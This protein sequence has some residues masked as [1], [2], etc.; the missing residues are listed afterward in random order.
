MEH[1]STKLVAIALTAIILLATMDTH[2]FVYPSLS[3]TL[4]SGTIITI[5]SVYTYYYCIKSKRILHFSAFQWIILLWMA[6]IVCHRLFVQAENYRLYYLL[7][8]LLFC[9]TV[10]TL[11][12]HGLLRWRLVENILLGV[13]V[14]HVAVIMFQLLKPSK[15]APYAITGC[16]E[17]PTVSAVYLTCCVT[18]VLERFNEHRKSYGIMLL[19]M[20]IAIL[21]LRCRT[22]YIGLFVIFAIYLFIYYMP[23][24]IIGKLS[25]M[26]GCTM[27]AI[28]LS[29]GL[30]HFKQSSSEGRLLIW[31]VTSRMIRENPI[32]YG[33]GLFEKNYNLHQEDYFSSGQGDMN[34]K[35]TATAVYMPYNDVLEQSVEGGITGALFYLLFFAIILKS[36]Y[37]QKDHEAFCIC[38][39][40]LV[41]SMVNFIYTAIPVWL[42]LMCVAGKIISAQPEAAKRTG[43]Q[44]IP[45][46]L[47]VFSILLC[48]RELKVI[49]AQLQLAQWHE[50]IGK[51]YAIEDNS[52][53]KLQS[54][55]E[56]SE[57]Y[58]T[59][60]G[61]NQMLLQQYDD[62]ATSFLA[63]LEYTSSPR[64][65]HLLSQCHL[66][67]GNEQ[68]FLRCM[69]TAGN[70]LPHHFWP[71]VLLMRYYNSH[72][73]KREAV[74]Y[75]HEIINMPVKVPSNDV[76]G[77]KNEA[78]K[79]ILSY[80]K[81]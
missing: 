24:T 41:M 74:L 29:A 60:L 61:K 42:L 49:W 37:R 73:Q 47:A 51:G 9:L 22:A 66:A 40:L 59:D 62:A 16:F 8:S 38:L 7:I 25:V 79:Q 55:I 52:M 4:L 44:L 10:S 19:S 39:S 69:T 76:A 31:K 57:C 23:K 14:V 46:T 81:K 71:R 34:E 5:L 54:V 27:I 68:G 1:S 78:H 17:N 20:F 58:Y 26:A 65:F 2:L 43:H 30:Y 32:G 21:L 6:Y 77:F 53:N 13:S 15:P 18:I 80:E 70:M 3:Q 33:Y 50:L 67:L 48:C 11:L 45:V 56:T 28:L 64:V 75:A 63:A 35:Q 36:A 12:R 72:N